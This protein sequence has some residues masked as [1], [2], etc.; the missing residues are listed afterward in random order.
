MEALNDETLRIVTRMKLEGY[1]SGE[2][3]KRL[4]VSSRTVDRKLQLI[5]DIWEEH[6][7]GEN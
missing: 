1:S 7:F 6:A 5:R 2:I 4:E 3:A